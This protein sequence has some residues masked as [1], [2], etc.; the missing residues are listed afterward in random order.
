MPSEEVLGLAESW[1]IFTTHVQPRRL[2]R[3][4]DG[5][6]GPL[7][8]GRKPTSRL[9]ILAN[10]LRL[11]FAIV[12]SPIYIFIPL[13]TAILAKFDFIKRILRW[14]I[15]WAETPDAVLLE[16]P[17][18]LIGEEGKIK[19]ASR[20]QYAVTGNK[21]RWLLEVEFRGNQIVS[22]RQVRYEWERVKEEALMA[23]PGNS[24]RKGIQRSGYTAIS[25]SMESAKELF[26]ESGCSL[27]SQP[28]IPPDGN[29]KYSLR[30]RQKISR[31]LLEEYARARNTINDKQDGF[32]FIWLDEFCLSNQELQDEQEIE[33]QRDTEVG[34]LADIFRGARRVVVFCHV[35]DCDHTGI[36]CPWAS[37]LFTM[38]EILYTPQVLQMSRTRKSNHQQKLSSYITII[39]GPEFRSDMQACAAEA[40]QWHLYN[41]MQHAT[42]SG[43]VTWQSAIHS[44]VVEAIR[45]DEAGEFHT[46]KF[47]G[48]A[49]DGLLPRRSQLE[50]LRG[51]NGWADLAWLLELNQGYYNAALLAAV[52]KLANHDVDE[53]RWWGEPIAPREGSERLE[54]LVHAIPV[55]FRKTPTRLPEPV[56]S[57]IGPKSVALSHWLQRDSFALY[58][59]PEM[60]SLSKA[61]IRIYLV[62]FFTVT[63]RGSGLFLLYLATI[64][65]SILV[66]LVG[67]MFVKKDVWFVIED[68]TTVGGDARCWLQSQ[69]ATFRK[70]VEWGARQLVPQWDTP[71]ASPSP[72]GTP[73]HPYAV[74]LVDLRTGVLVKAAVTKRP[75]GMV[76]LAIH[77][78]GITWM[79][80][81]RDDK[82]V[83]VTPAVKVGMV[84]LPPFVLAQAEESGT[85]YV[86]GRQEGPARVHAHT[87]GDPPAPINH[88]ERETSDQQHPSQQNKAQIP[89]VDDHSHQTKSSSIDK[90]RILEYMRCASMI[91]KG[92]YSSDEDSVRAPKIDIQV[93]DDF[94]LFVLGLDLPHPS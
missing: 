90:S 16:S 5:V 23:K 11:F 55:T 35:E 87:S 10:V 14:S 64:A 82:K 70:A 62:I 69:D 59:N 80:L 21:P 89:K 88:P 37:R 67:T 53:Y 45:R 44:L 57:I 75:N 77:G 30:N 2:W 36:D 52:C 51:I 83:K 22:Q 78:S 92:Y 81:D 84:N 85:V 4:D 13:D 17:S 8:F 31:A 54:A 47:L 65:Y 79:L 94:H 56:L 24:L 15:E 46:H 33:R 50:D 19:V 72:P 63:F 58:R 73:P 41:I 25:Y 60:K 28:E 93:L 48:K 12:F 9:H 43:A 3:E 38:G 27:D 6:E 40:K 39:P 68:H 18:S 74:T 76:A 29:R 32:E 71:H 61:A 86:S 1:R 26:F 42:N 66:L 49:L 91:R 20:G 34:Q 7:L